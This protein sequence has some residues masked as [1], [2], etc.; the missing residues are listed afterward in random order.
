MAPAVTTLGMRA[1]EMREIA[2]VIAD[3][4][5]ATTPGVIASGKNAGK[6][7]LVQYRLDERVA[8]AARERSAD[9]LDRHPLY[10]G[11]DLAGLDSLPGT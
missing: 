7:S 9:L 4:L 1:D 3:V 8:Q 2:D 5:H 11:I 6:P 10:P